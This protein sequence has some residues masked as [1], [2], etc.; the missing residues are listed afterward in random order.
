MIISVVSGK[1][2]TGKSTF[3][4]GLAYSF[5][6]AGKSVLLVDLDIGLRS[7]DIMLGL[8]H[9]VVFDLGDVIDDKCKIADAMSKHTVYSSLKLLCSPLN[10]SKSFDIHKVIDLIKSQTSLFDN[11]VLDLPAGLGLSII[12]AKELADLICVMTAPDAITIRD[13]RKVCDVLSSS[14]SKDF[15][16]VINHVC[17]SSMRTSGLRDLDELM[18]GVGA[19]LLGVL[20]EDDWISNGFRPSVDKRGN[21]KPLPE[22]IKAF[23]AIAKRIDGKYVPLVIRST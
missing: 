6:K 7:L 1:G 3:S 9:K 2:G 5:A 22:T 4:A 21:K 18:D 23:D 19:P 20:K 17:K 10:I 8:E 14:C 12:M 15:K 11:I 13:T 16:I